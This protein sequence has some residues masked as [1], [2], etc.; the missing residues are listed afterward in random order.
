[1]VCSENLLERGRG[2]TGAVAGRGNP[3]DL[4]R[5]E[6]VESVGELR[7]GDAPGR[8]DRGE[9][10]HLAVVVPH[11]E[12][13]DV[14]GLDAAGRLG[15]E[16]DPPLAAEAVELVD[17]DAA[18][19]RLER[20]VDVADL[21]ALLQDLV[22]VDVGVDLGHRGAP[23]AVDVGELG[24]LPRGLQELLEVL[25]QEL[26]G[27]AAA[28]LEPEREA[29]A[30]AEALDG[31]RLESDDARFQDLRAELSVQAADDRAREHVVALALVP[32]VEPDEVEGG[33]RRRG[34]GEEAEAGD[35]R[36][37][38][39]ALRLREELLDF[40][41]HRVGPLERGG[42]GKLDVQ[43]EVALVLVGEKARGKPLAEQARQNDEPAEDQE[44]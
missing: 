19:E 13:V 30:G 40:L 26:D 10:R 37:V 44:R 15:L 16:E 5:P 41:A 17:V 20:L 42:V 36:D 21:D 2:L 6:E 32:G 12:L 11:V 3:R 7:P 8:H 24:A 28:V 31:G 25:L 33:V 35:R 22:A 9:R 4:R 1:M 34:A 38:L 18:E 23:D 29:A 27:S 43:E 14:L 39:D